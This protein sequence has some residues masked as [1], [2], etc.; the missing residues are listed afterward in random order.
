MQCEGWWEAELGGVRD[1]PFCAGVSEKVSGE[2]C[3]G[4]SMAVLRNKRIYM[5]EVPSKIKAV[6]LSSTQGGR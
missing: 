1:T 4:G 6:N 3:D 5:S 2:P